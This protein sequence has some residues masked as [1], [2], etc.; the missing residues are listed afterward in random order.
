LRANCLTDNND[1]PIPTFAEVVAFAAGRQK[2]IA[3]EVKD[4]NLTDA[5]LQGFVQ[6]VRGNGMTSKTFV[7]SFY[8]AVFPRLRTLE[9]GLTFV[10]LTDSSTPPATVRNSA[11]T[12]AG[13]NRSGLTAAK[14]AAYHAAG[15]PV[16][17]YTASTAE[18][19]KSVWDMRVD[20]VFT[21]IPAT[22]REMYHPG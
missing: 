4:N 16:W 10:Y 11:A 14:V 21:D 13:L 3:P 15:L 2:A 19:L 8:P 5:E 9:S 22:A 20:G 1:G 17:S 6:V 7:Q 12:I 18:H